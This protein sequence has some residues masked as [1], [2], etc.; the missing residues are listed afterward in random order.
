MQ[1]ARLWLMIGIPSLALLGGLAL[2][3]I[4]YFDPAATV[5]APPVGFPTRNSRGKCF[6]T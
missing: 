2:V 4:G 1:K 3:L 6:P 5:I